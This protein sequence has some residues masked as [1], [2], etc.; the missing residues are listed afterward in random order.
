MSIYQKIL[1]AVDLSEE[2]KYLL[3][4]ASKFAETFTAELN[5]V[6]VVQPLVVDVGYDLV[7]S[8]PQDIDLSLVD[9]AEK[10]LTFLK[11]EVSQPD[12]GCF[13]KIGSIKREIL[14]LAAEQQADLIMIGTHGRHGV[15]LLLGS[16]AGAVLHG[17]PCDVLAVRVGLSP[18]QS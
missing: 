4:R 3:Q 16:N 1:V 15:A 10:F 5:L 11:A 2:A 12:I 18:R 14:D 9:R 13:V 6:H 17:T 8:I 7:A